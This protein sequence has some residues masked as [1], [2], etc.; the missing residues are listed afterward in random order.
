[1]G[2]TVPE[3]LGSM[4]YD[5]LIDWTL[6]AKAE[7]FGEERA[8]FRMAQLCALTANLQRDPKQRP[9]AWTV[10][11]FMPDFDREAEPEP[12]GEEEGATV[13]PET[14]AYLFGAVRGQL[15]QEAEA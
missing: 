4:S 12:E 1:M 8:D 3:M 9:E 13:H 15:V 14:I 11:D 10:Q 6:Y 7:P 2:R 5:E